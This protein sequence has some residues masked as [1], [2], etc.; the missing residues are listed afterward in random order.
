MKRTHVGE[1]YVLGF[2]ADEFYK[3]GPIPF[4]PL[5]ASFVIFI[6][7]MLDIFML[8]ENDVALAPSDL[9]NRVER[10]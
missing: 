8:E 5:L 2:N 9:R 3:L 7:N 6:R 4:L 1:L 10:N